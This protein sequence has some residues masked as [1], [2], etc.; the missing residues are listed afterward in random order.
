M[1]EYLSPLWKWCWKHRLETSEPPHDKINKMACAPIEDSDQPGKI[2]NEPRHDKINKNECAPSEDSDQPGHPL[3]LIRVF[4]V[5]MKKAW[6]LSDPL[7]AQ[8]RLRS[9]FASRRLRSCPGWSESSLGISLGIAK[10][11]IMPRLIWVFAGRTVILLVLSWD[12]SFL[13][14]VLISP[15]VTARI[16]I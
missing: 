14:R 12:G 6:I 9:A 16:I 2:V 1:S 7:S 13:L 4:A 3:S 15:G 8:R 10:T 11:Q 5:R